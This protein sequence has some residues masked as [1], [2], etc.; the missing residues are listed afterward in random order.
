MRC[1]RS[2]S[3]LTTEP[4]SPAGG[5]TDRIFMSG[6]DAPGSGG[7]GLDLVAAGIHAIGHLFNT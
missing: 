6:L 2:G 4:A 1:W 7:L 5:L 3:A